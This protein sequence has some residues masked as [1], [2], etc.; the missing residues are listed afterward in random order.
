MLQATDGE[1]P[2][3]AQRGLKE[4]LRTRGMFLAC[5]CRPTGKLTVRL[6]AG[7]G[8]RVAAVVR[9][10]ESIGRDVAR[11]RIACTGPFDYFPGQFV[12]VVRPAD[13]LTRSYSLASLHSPSGLPAG[14][15]VLE[16]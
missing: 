10:V 16:L 8:A 15:D 5:S 14:D 2:A 3:D 1:L 9:G 13:G 4:S 11:V 6:P 12:N 7:A